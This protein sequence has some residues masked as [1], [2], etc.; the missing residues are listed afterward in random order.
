VPDGVSVNVFLT[1][2]TED[3]RH[4]EYSTRATNG[5]SPTD[6]FVRARIYIY[7]YIY[8]NTGVKAITYLYK[9]TQVVF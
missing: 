8:I 1:P 6:L 9:G 4:L 5:T 2:C 3:A 7:I